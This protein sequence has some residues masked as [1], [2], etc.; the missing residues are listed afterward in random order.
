MILTEDFLKNEVNEYNCVKNFSLFLEDKKFNNKESYDLFISHSFMDKQ[1]V[2]V[3]YKKFEEAGYKVYI[4]WK[5]AKLQDRE[6]VSSETA[7]IL[8]ERMNQCSGLSYIATGNNV[9]SKWCPWELGY[10]DGKKNRAAILPILNSRNNEYKGLEY[11][12]IYPYIDYEKN[13]K[14]GKYEF[15]V[16]DSK[17][18]NKYTVLREWLETGNLKDHNA[19]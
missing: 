19:N 14:S 13:K 15:W 4:D 2:G 5:E 10:A 12:G 9:N 1:L 6:N 3:L 8:R 7:K 16:N 11:L 18:R 17:D